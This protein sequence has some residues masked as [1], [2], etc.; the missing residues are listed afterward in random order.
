M[1]LVRQGFYKE[2][3]VG[4]TTDPSIMRGLNKAKPEEAELVSSYLDSGIVLITCCGTS[5]DIIKPENGIAGVPSV[6][7]DGKW[8]WPGDLSYYVKNYQLALDPEF[9]SYMRKQD[10][11]VSLKREELNLSSIEMDG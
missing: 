8:V 4:K 3:A 7:T 1:K 11:R 6:L 2:M 10:W 9:V 5:I